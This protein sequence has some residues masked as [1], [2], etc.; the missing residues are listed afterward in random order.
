MVFDELL[1]KLTDTGSGRDL[2]AA[3]YYQLDDHTRLPVRW[4]AWE[5]LFMVS[6]LTKP[7]SCLL[8]D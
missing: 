7:T 4:I 8:D 6:Q 3:D 2:Y 5:A 1:V